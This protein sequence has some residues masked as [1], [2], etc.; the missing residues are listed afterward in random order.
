MASAGNLPSDGAD[1][2]RVTSPER[3][4]ELLDQATRQ[5]RPAMLDFY[6]DWCISC[7]VM[8]RT[9]FSDGRVGEALRPYT[10][11]Q[12]DITDNTPEQQALLNEL[13]IFGP[14]AILFYNGRGKELENQRVLGEMDRDQ[15]LDHLDSVAR[16]L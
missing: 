14:P 7:K 1:F 11:L 3:L 2:Q 4:R 10:L 9:V 15:F 8:D 12:L 6:A 16:A 13:G 5:G